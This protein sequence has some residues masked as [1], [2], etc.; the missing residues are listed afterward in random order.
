MG[1]HRAGFDVIGVDIAPQPNYPFRF[2]QADALQVSLTGYDFIWASPPCQG[3]SDL[4]HRSNR[5]YLHLIEPVRLRLLTADTPFVI[6]NVDTAP[7]LN[8]KMLCGT[9]FDLK[10]FRHRLF[11][12]NFSWDMPT[13]QVHNGSTGT[14]RW[15]YRRNGGY[16]QVT[17]GGNCT[18]AEAQAAMGIDWMIKRELNEAIPP[19]YSQ[20]IAEQFLRNSH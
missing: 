11:E 13:H 17:G 1:L 18:V 15:P 6:E 9:M 12:A 5:E 20:Y 19:A 2:M 3:Y 16:V 14:H 8:P 10:V 4:R 7:L